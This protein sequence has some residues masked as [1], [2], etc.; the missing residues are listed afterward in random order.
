VVI[1][2][3]AI[4]MVQ[5][6]EA[7]WRRTSV[8]RFRSDPVPDEV[9][10]LVLDAATRAPTG[11]NMQPWEFLLVTDPA[12]KEALVQETYAGFYSG[13]GNPQLWIGT[14][15]VLVIV[16]CN[17]KRTLARYGP[18]GFKW[19]PLDVAA[20]TQNM[21]L[22]AVEA[23][24]G[25]CWI[26]GFRELEVCRLLGLPELVKPIGFLPM[27]WPAERPAPKPRLPLRLITHRN[28]YGA[29]H[30]PCAEGG[31]ELNDA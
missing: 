7:I 9:V 19:A 18:D 25:C 27:G 8:R 13:P 3:E 21:I 23:G 5:R 30:F 20:A 22:T 17:H 29:P 31:D 24:L 1:M 10:N 11:G 12:L 28:R 14:A 26:G 4:A 2:T 15:P 16:L 6:I